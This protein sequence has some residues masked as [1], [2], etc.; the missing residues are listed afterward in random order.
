MTPAPVRL[1]CGQRHAGPLCSNGHVMCCICFERVPPSEL[2]MTSDG[3]LEDVC[4]PC[5]SAELLELEKRNP[6]QT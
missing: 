4:R 1:C 6:T 5:A 2:H 3:K